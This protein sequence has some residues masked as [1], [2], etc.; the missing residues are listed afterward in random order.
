MGRDT[1]H[2]AQVVWSASG[3]IGI[4]SPFPRASPGQ[5]FAH[6][7]E[8]GRL[9]ARCNRPPNALRRLV[10]HQPLATAFRLSS[11]EES[12]G[13]TVQPVKVPDGPVLNYPLVPYVVDRHT[14][15]S[16]R[17]IP[18]G[19]QILSGRCPSR[20]DSPILGNQ[21][22]QRQF[23]ACEASANLADRHEVAAEIRLR[24][25]DEVM[26]AESSVE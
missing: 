1:S 14:V 20:S 3:P 13:L 4:W 18:T 24:V 21:F 15:N 6:P 26:M 7:P 17:Y 12:G 11:L 8:N 23:D 25:C 10:W 22:V 5:G 9:T 19:Q 16:D 2:Y